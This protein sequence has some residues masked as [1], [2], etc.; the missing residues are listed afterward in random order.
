[1]RTKLNREHLWAETGR[2][3][4][5]QFLEV[6]VLLG[7]ASECFGQGTVS[8]NNRVAG[9]VVAPVYS[10]DPDCITRTGNTSAGL[11]P[12]TQVYGGP[13]IFGPGYTAQLWVAPGPGQPEN[14]LV[15]VAPTTTFGSNVLTGYLIP[16][17]LSLPGIAPGMT[18]T[19]QL[20]VW[21]NRGGTVVTWT[22][23]M[24]DPT[25][26]KGRSPL[27]NLANIQAPPSP[28]TPLAGLVSFSICANCQPSIGLSPQNQQTLPGG[29]VTLNV[30]ASGPPPLSYQWTFNG[31]NLSDNGRINGASTSALVIHDVQSGDLGN[32]AARVSNPGGSTTSSNATLSFATVRFS[33]ITIAGANCVLSFPTASGISY[34]VQASPSTN[35]PWSAVSGGIIGTGGISTLTV[36]I[37]TPQRYF[38]LMASALGAPPANPPVYSLNLVGYV[39][40]NAPAGSSQVFNPFSNLRLQDALPNP[41]DG[42]VVY[43]FVVD[44]YEVYQFDGFSMAWIPNGTVLL[45]A[46]TNFTLNAPASF[47]FTLAGEVASSS[48]NQPPTITSQPANQTVPLGGNASFQVVAAGT[49]PLNYQWY[50]GAHLLPGAT[51]SSLALPGVNCGSSGNFTVSINNAFGTVVSGMV[52]LTVTPTSPGPVI[53]Q[54]D[55][56]T[57]I[58]PNGGFP[59]TWSGG[60]ATNA[61]ASYVNGTGTAGSR[62][63][64]LTADFPQPVSAGSGWVAYQYEDPYVTINT[65]SNLS[66]YTLDFD[67]GVTG[68]PLSYL[69]LTVQGWTNTFWDGTPTDSG[70]G[71]VPLA[72]VT[73]FQHVTVNLG[74]TNIWSTNHFNPRSGTIHFQFQVN[75]GGFGTNGPVMGER[76]VIDNIVLTKNMVWTWN[77]SVSSDAY[78]PA[79]WTPP[80]VPESG[81]TINFNGG[82]MNLTVPTTLSGQVNWTAGTLTGNPLTLTSTGVL[83]ISGNGSKSIQMPLLNSGSVLWSGGNLLV[84]GDPGFA[85]RIENQSSGRFEA[86][87]DSTLSDVGTTGGAVFNNAGTFRKTSGTGTTTLSLVF[88]NSGTVDIQSGQ[89]RFASGGQLG[90]TYSAALGSLVRFDAGNFY[91]LA[92]PVLSGPGTFRF[93]GGNLT[94]V[95]DVIPNLQLTGGILTLGPLFQGGAINNL[96]LSGSTLAGNYPVGGVLN[97]VGGTIDGSL[98]VL[99][100]GVMNIL[101]TGA[102]Y[103]QGPLTNAGSGYWSGSGPIYIYA[104]FGRTGR[105]ENQA[106]G[107]FQA[108][109]DATMYDAWGTGNAVFNN[110]GTFR[111]SAGTGVSQLA[112]TFRNS[113]TLAAEVGTVAC[114]GTNFSQLGGTLDLGLS[115]PTSNGMISFSAPLTMGGTLRA[116]LTGGYVPSLSDTFLLLLYPSQTGAF[117]VT[118]LPTQALWAVN[119]GTTNLIITATNTLTPP[120]ITTQPQSQSVAVG[121]TVDFH[122]A[123]EGTG[124]L[125]YEW[126]FNGAPIPGA[127]SPTTLSLGNVQ[128]G[129]AGNY[130]VVVAGPG[131]QVTSSIAV[132]EVLN[133][134]VPPPLAD[135]T[136]DGHPDDVFSNNP[137]AVLVNTLFTNHSL[138]LNGQYELNEPRGFRANAGVGGLS[139]ASFT[140]ALDFNPIDLDGLGHDTILMGGTG[141]RWI[142]LRSITGY[143]ELNL[144]NHSLQ[145]P[146][147]DA[148][149]SSNQWH[150]VVC[151]VDVAQRKILVYLD[152]RKL[153]TVTLPPDFQFEVVGTPSEEV[154]K[155][156]TFNDYSRGSAFYGF[157]ANLTVF[158]RALSAAD[159]T[160]LAA[161]P[162]L[163]LLQ[164]QNQAVAP[165]GT[166]ILSAAA[167]GQPPLTYQWLHFGAVMLGANSA[168]LELPN[169]GAGELG[170]YQVLVSNAYGSNVSAVATVSF[171]GTP[172]SIL[173]HPQSQIVAVGSNVTFSVTATG[174]PPPGYQWLFN[175]VALPGATQ[176]SFTIGAVT[177]GDGGSYRV[178]V[179]NPNGSVTSLPATLTVYTAPTIT[180]PPASAQVTIGSPAHFTVIASSSGP[181]S[182]QW[183]FDGALIPGATT[184]SFMIASAQQTDAGN[185][186]VQV[187]GL[188]G[189]VTSPDAA[190]VVVPASNPT[191]VRQSYTLNLHAGMNLIAN[192]LDTGGNNLKEIMPLVPNGC[193]V[194]KFDNL[195]GTWSRS[196]Y[197]AGLQAWA[198]ANTVLRPGDGAFLE[199]PIA[200]SLTFTGTPHTPVLPTVIPN[201]HIY[202][203]S[204]QTNDVGTFENIIGS[205]P[206]QGAIVYKWTGIA[207]DAYTFNADGWFPEVPGAA[208]GEAVW[209]AAPNAAGPVGIPVAPTITQQPVGVSVTRGGHATLSVQ[210]TGSTPLYFQWRL[211]GN[212]IPGA[213]SNVLDL[214]NVQPG[215]AGNYS[216]V[217]YNVI[218]VASSDTVTLTV[219]DLNNLPFADLFANAGSLG[220]APSGAGTGSNVGATTGVG[221]PTPLG[222][223]G[224]A[225]VWLS[226][227]PS[228]SGVATFTTAGSS[229]DTLLGAY[230]GTV[231]TNLFV[232]AS[233]DDSAPFLCSTITFGVTA[234]TTY[235]IQ[236]DGFRGVSGT[237]NLAW[238]LVP[239]PNP[240]PLILTQPLSQTIPAGSNATLSVVVFEDAAFSYQW[241]FHGAPLPGATDSTLF[242]P[243]L[244]ESQ[245]GPYVVAITNITTGAGIH[246]A[247][248]SLQ[249]IVSDAGQTGNPANVSAQD[250]F[251]S[252]AALTP[253]DPNVIHDPAPA[254]SFTGT[255]TFSTDG[256][257]ADPSEPNHCGYAP[258][259]TYWCSYL[260]PAT[261]LLTIDSHNTAFNGVLAVYTGPG[262]DF[263]SLVPVACNANHGAYVGETVTFAATA[264]TQYWVVIM[265]IGCATGNAT[266][267]YSLTATPIFTA[268][269]VSQTL[270]T[271][272]RLLLSATVVGAP[273]LSYQW[274]LN[275]TNLPGA[276]ASSLTIASFQA[277]NQGNYSLVASNLYGTNLSVSASVLLNDPK[278]V[279]YS[280]SG[281]TFSA[282]FVGSA[283]SNYV[284]ESSVNLRNWT[285][286][287]TNS[288]AI[289]II[290]FSDTAAAGVGK[291]YR[292]RRQ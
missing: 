47:S 121:A 281:S 243:G 65:S 196:V 259:A 43:I 190:L 151:S 249:L 273:T 58:T 145:Y 42:T 227:Q 66:D 202:L 54:E 78:N 287:R 288:S 153:Q 265:G 67:L 193:V 130:S 267:N 238:N 282:Q 158:G 103:L 250:K 173:L 30:Q 236:V 242:L 237:I 239:S 189:S 248:A 126:R 258:C 83:N 111:K 84:N 27:F 133:V 223:P 255:Q 138:Y 63:V 211:N 278:F 23:A 100:N 235:F 124:P 48:L 197:D 98:T 13:L 262:S 159:I 271:G 166:A 226:W 19:L 146:F 50:F 218:A 40:V 87:S 213:T 55:F 230:T 113:G 81:D 123:A 109:G 20:K 141:Y 105:I 90:G 279:S 292:A 26:V 169:V 171:L 59:T 228:I 143:L 85:G 45:P 260:A 93:S 35:G 177:V 269:P 119:V 165:G 86:Q 198:P 41:P 253:P 240:L 277:R 22:Q 285:P 92:V 199:S 88:N 256:A 280:K 291:F 64:R 220:S 161:S 127:T 233:D 266:I 122:V 128:T 232:A 167:A 155:L 91:Y 77:G 263:A 187:S 183:Y 4:W 137:P 275:G 5:G 129:Q 231:L 195:S 3:C 207:Y 56:E 116:H 222:I 157:A 24:A 234:G 75:N 144:N 2:S 80:G 44:H 206:Q 94:L 89:V 178:A 149:L 79:N 39:N 106:G 170:P 96:T 283:R 33:G 134:V 270:A 286:I 99:S 107:L 36:P 192:Q 224:G 8:L 16:V 117:N 68:V 112:L 72:A 212:N 164:P 185:Y 156:F 71:A 76:I 14:L 34:Q 104:D 21:D 7:I 175:G 131:G 57:S 174:D 82:T 257:T 264:G 135:F 46:G 194:H 246:S 219:S 73:G 276:T 168:T 180:V 139:Y 61:V 182:Y 38:R 205:T 17:N 172:P 62:A 15:P 208:V 51:S 148:I 120:T 204:R 244:V 150:K 9:V 10:C 216:V 229:F 252:A 95:N 53:I 114:T 97:W 160:A 184:S 272:S 221:E 210:A 70:P 6:L 152:G 132:L 136:F 25:I 215:N 179:S 118:D 162:P 142:G 12:G 11:P 108:E 101:G 191:V 110:A 154:E 247:I 115:G 18:A 241:L 1:M 147:P 37:T 186:A 49:P 176:S 254:G 28:P 217:V 200:F 29:T 31:A 125:T 74:N 69:Q 225:S 201:G 203:L 188:A 274:R 251:S 284:F 60:T 268:Q 32:Y 163:F 102:K 209:I 214:V 290:N 289:G 261:G 181:L 245:V 140:V 52:G